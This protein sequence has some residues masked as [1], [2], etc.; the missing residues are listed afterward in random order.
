ML[1]AVCLQSPPIVRLSAWGKRRALQSLLGA[2]HPIRPRAC[3][4]CCSLGR[5]AASGT[6]ERCGGETAT[7]RRQGSPPEIG[8]SPGACASP[9]PSHS[10]GALLVSWGYVRTR[11][12]AR[13]DTARRLAVGG[14]RQASVHRVATA[15]PTTSAVHVHSSASSSGSGCRGAL[16]AHVRWSSTTR[17]ALLDAPWSERTTDV[18]FAGST[19]RRTDASELCVYPC[20]L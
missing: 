6:V 20:R 19:R 2:G 18:C 7:Q 1:C 4:R 12:A 16:M 14:R 8:M 17:R 9:S 3:K 10:H 13:G 15:C 11:R 5:S